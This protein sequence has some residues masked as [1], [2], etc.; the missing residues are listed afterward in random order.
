MAEPKILIVDDELIV[1]KSA[2]RVLKGEGYSAEGALGGREAIMKLG[3]ESYDL[4]FT[5]LKMPEVD[6]ITLIRWIKKMKPAIGIVIITGY[7]SQDTI[8]DALE[9]GI[10]DYVPKPFT[11]SVLLDV[12]ERAVQWTRGRKPEEAKKTEEFPP[13]MAAELDRVVAQLKKKPG[14]LIPVLQRAQEIVGYLPPI[15][16]KR[17]A[18]GLNIPEAEVHSVVSFYSFFTMRPRG[19]HN[20]RV[21]LGTACYVKGIEGVLKKIQDTLKIDV[22][23][24]TENRRFSVEAV[25][26]L[27][28][29]GLAPV[30]M[31]DQETYGAM[32]PKKALEK[33][34]QFDP[35]I[36]EA[37]SADEAE[38]LAEKEA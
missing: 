31:I 3:Q 1:I 30:M 23:E 32:T 14:A 26:C 33:I 13:A 2:E 19:D 25:R 18:K 27:G 11:P 38:E 7:P 10:I 4:V 29:C 35:T 28:A 21:C 17:I 37:P 9:L 6:G 34:S 5:D 24:T 22:G 8:K 20:I 12:T 16:Q 15:V 36:L